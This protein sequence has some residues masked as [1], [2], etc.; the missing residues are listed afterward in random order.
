MMTTD[1]QTIPNVEAL[2]RE[3][4]KKMIRQQQAVKF[5][6]KKVNAVGLAVSGVDQLLET[7]KNNGVTIDDKITAIFENQKQLSDQFNA[8]DASWREVSKEQADETDLLG[9]FGNILDQQC[10]NRA[11]G[12][13]VLNKKVSENHE[14]AI[15]DIEAIKK[16]LVVMSNQLHGL[17]TIDQLKSFSQAVDRLSAEI[18]ALEH[19]RA[20]HQ[21]S[22][23]QHLTLL[24]AVA[25]LLAQSIDHYDIRLNALSKRVKKI[26]LTIDAIDDRLDDLTPRDLDMSKNDIL[27]MFE[28]VKPAIEEPVSEPDVTSNAPVK[29]SEAV[30]TTEDVSKTEA[31]EAHEAVEYAAPQAK[32]Q[33]VTDDF[34]RRHDAKDAVNAEDEHPVTD[35][36]DEDAVNN[37]VKDDKDDDAVNGNEKDDTKDGAKEQ[38]EKKHFWSRWIK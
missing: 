14:N 3:I 9:E 28:Q 32:A 10:A 34:E 19:Q 20:A 5:L 16:R 21:T 38:P 29:D 1:E 30:E 25:D 11:N 8:L 27:A 4:A 33:V 36:K 26:D 23:N 6:G 2:S 35:G 18:E 15:H 7:L 31:S 12:L 37:G 22:I 17:D 24:T 13:T